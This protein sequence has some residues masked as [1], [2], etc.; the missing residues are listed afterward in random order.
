MAVL[1]VFSLAVLAWAV[2]AGAIAAG[3]GNYSV[4]TRWPVGGSDKWDYLIV[5]APHHHLFL[6]RSTRVQVL[7]L[8][9][10]KLVGEIANTPGVHGIA[11]AQDLHRGFTSNGK[12]ASVTV[13]DLDTLATITEIRI[14][15][16]DP[17][18]IIYDAPSHRIYALN[19]HSNSATVIDAASAREIATIA[20][21][22]R[23]EF[24]VSD[25]EGHVFVN[26]EDKSLVAK[27]DVAKGAVLSSWSL[28]PCLEPTGLALDPV[29]HRLFSVCHNEKMI[30]SDSESGKRIA[31][32][33]IGKHVD[34]AAFD[35]ALG[36]VFCSNGDSANVSLIE[37]QPGDRYAVRGALATVA[38]AKTMAL[39]SSTHRI[40]VP[41]MSTDGVQILV[42][43]PR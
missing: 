34:A 1:K 17:D 8:E 11:L 25:G 20:L 12:G 40:Y 5:D 32:L 15:G 26:L 36:L 10:G 13:F 33:P 37:V 6:S 29:R 21:P 28:A 38:G 31:E 24:A 7:D 9:S 16:N 42:A 23:P 41:A 2:T 35:P 27:I 3:D 14:S 22:G 19:G 30:I 39:D 43:A 4:V 18:A